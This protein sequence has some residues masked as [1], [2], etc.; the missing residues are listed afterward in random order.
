MIRLMMMA[1]AMAMALSASMAWAQSLPAGSFQIPRGQGC[2]GGY[3]L[4]V[5]HGPISS[6]AGG[7]DSW[8]C[9]PGG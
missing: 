7:A 9:V 8:W 4:V 3:H 2:P 5:L 6:S 1:G